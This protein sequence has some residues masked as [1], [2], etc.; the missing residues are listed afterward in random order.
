MELVELAKLLP[1]QQAEGKA[2]LEFIRTPSL[3]VGTYLLP[4]GG[5]DTQQ[6]HTEDEV[7]YV[8]SGNGSI[9][10][11][12]EEQA[13]SPGSTIL[14]KANVPHHFHSITEALTLLVFF[15]PAEYTNK[16]GN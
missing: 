15:A 2:Y 3:S 5:V 9:T 1:E 13:V 11:G 8:I 6:P 7:Y 16:D 10:V 12:E 4:A 14:V